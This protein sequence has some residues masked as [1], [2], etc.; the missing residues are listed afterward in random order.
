MG[1]TGWRRS[2]L[3][4]LF[5]V[6]L[7][8]GTARAEFRLI[9]DFDG[10]DE[11]PINGQNG[12]FAQSSNSVVTQDPAGG[13]NQVLS[14]NT[15][16]TR[17]HKDALL[18]N[19]TIRM[20]FLRFRYA[21]QLNFS[22]GMSERSSPDQFH[23]FDPELSMTNA[24]SELRINDGGTYDVL[25]TL[26]PN[27]WYNCWLL[28]DNVNDESQVWLH[29]RPGESATW[30]DQLDSDGQTVF[31]FRGGS[32]LDLMT[33]FIK[34]GGGSGPAGPLYLDDIYMED[35]NALNLDNPS[36]VTTGVGEACN[37]TR[38]VVIGSFPN[39]FTATTAV[40]LTLPE[41]GEVEIAIFD[42]S[43]RRVVG[44]IA[45]QAGN[46][47]R[48]FLWDGRDAAGQAVAP[49]VYFVRVRSG[50]SIG[51]ERLVRMQ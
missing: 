5:A 32:A 20:L 42:A 44:A 33:F 12:W 26:D 14:V 38:P 29:G 21:D 6:L 36:G 1:T 23:D 43:G 4:G 51:L 35:T 39:P 45:E 16:S 46:R 47:D 15:E 3:V 19:G 41:S 34:T 8:G 50:V 31:A 22:L 48:I 9:E 30:D 24:T 27:T 17:L 37:G 25:T 2:G 40:H 13:D 10:L 49:G 18:L 28:I 11:G 7:V